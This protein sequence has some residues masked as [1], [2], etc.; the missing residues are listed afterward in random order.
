M[1]HSS[2]IL[3]EILIWV[4]GKE[5]VGREWSESYS[6]FC[7]A[8]FLVTLPSWILPVGFK[9]LKFTGLTNNREKKN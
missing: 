5:P 2:L 3:L 9:Q 6:P 7:S 4:E 1:T 8:G